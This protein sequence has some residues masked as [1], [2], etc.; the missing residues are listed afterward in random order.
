MQLLHVFRRLSSAVIRPGDF[1]AESIIQDPNVQELIAEWEDKCREQ[2]RAPEARVLLNRVLA[3]RSFPMT[4]DVRSRIDGEPDVTRLESWL[5][6]AVTAISIGEVFRD[7]RRRVRLTGG[8]VVNR[9][10]LA[11]LLATASTTSEESAMST[12]KAGRAAVNGLSL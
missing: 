5:E 9:L 6:A 4:P 11:T 1:P 7:A 3:A 10:A 2:G 8:A 12:K